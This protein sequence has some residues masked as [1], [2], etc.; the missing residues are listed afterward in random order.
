LRLAAAT[1]MTTCELM[2][3]DKPSMLRV[4]RDE[5]LLSERFM[6]HLLARNS[7]VEED[8]VDQLFNSSEKR[9]AVAAMTAAFDTVCQSLSTRMN[10]NDEARRALAL[11]IL[12]R[13]DQGERDP[14]RLVD[15]GLRELVRTDLAATE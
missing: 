10:G 12:R 2:R 3:V 14:T 13:V 6:A 11:A 7:R 5:P 15:L 9:L 8:L 1:A 4:L